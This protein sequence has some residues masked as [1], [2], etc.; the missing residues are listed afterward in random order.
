MSTCLLIFARRNV[1]FQQNAPLIFHK[2]RAEE[3]VSV[4]E[5]KKRSLISSFDSPRKFDS[6]REYSSAGGGG[7]RN[8]KNPS[9]FSENSAPCVKSCAF[10]CESDPFIGSR[11]GRPARKSPPAAAAELNV[12]PARV[13]APN[14]S[15]RTSIWL[16]GASSTRGSRLRAR[17]RGSLPASVSRASERAS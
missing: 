9:R 16:E 13:V 8:G 7:G 17:L 5:G 11:T 6:T 12:G 1:A 15:A 2:I 4:S 10:N 14:R 3:T